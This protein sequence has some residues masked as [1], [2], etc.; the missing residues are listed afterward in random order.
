MKI[1]REAH[2][3]YYLDCNN[4]GS[5]VNNLIAI[6]EWNKDFAY[7]NDMF[8]CVWW[9]KVLEDTKERDGIEKVVCCYGYSGRIVWKPQLCKVFLMIYYQLT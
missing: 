1:V 9:S 2:E 5:Y 3:N 6:C 8:I 7:I 4:N